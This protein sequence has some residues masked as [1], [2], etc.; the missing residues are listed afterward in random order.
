MIELK[1]GKATHEGV[2][3]LARYVHKVQAFQP[4]GTQVRGILV[5]PDVTSPALKQLE[6][7]GL[8]FKQLTALPQLERANPQTS[9]F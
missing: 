5:A 2:H 8:E 1:R 6:A 7:E 3:Q 9:L 4:A